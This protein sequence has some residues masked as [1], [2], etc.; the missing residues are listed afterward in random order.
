MERVMIGIDN[1]FKSKRADAY[2][3]DTVKCAISGAALVVRTGPEFVLLQSVP[4]VDKG[5][6]TL[7][8]AL[9]NNGWCGA[10]IRL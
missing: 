7:E 5:P 3:T 1:L 2:G 6:V 4:S 9:E 10:F 8:V